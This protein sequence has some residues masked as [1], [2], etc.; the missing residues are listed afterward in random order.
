MLAGSQFLLGMLISGLIIA[1]VSGSYPALVLSSCNLVAILKGAKTSGSKKSMLLR[2]ILV[3]FQFGVSVGLIFCTIVTSDQLGFIKNRDLGFNKD[4]VIN[5]SGQNL[6]QRF[7][8][9]KNEVQQNS[10]ILD[11]TV[12]QRLP[13]D[14]GMAHFG[15]WEG[16]NEGEKPVFYKNQVGYDFIDFYE[17]EIVEGRNFS[18]EYPSDLD[19]AYILNETAVKNIG[20]GDPIGKKF[21]LGKIDGVIVGVLKDFHFA[22]LK[23]KIEPLA[24]RLTNEGGDWISIKIR[25]ENIKSSISFLEK[26][27]QTY[28]PGYPFSFSFLDDGF[29]RMYKKEK[30]LNDS[31]GYFAIIAIFIAYLGLFGLVSFSAERKTKE[32]GIRKVVGAS[33]FGIMVLHSKEFMKWVILANVIA[34]PAAYFVMNKWLQT[35]AYRINIGVGTFILSGAVAFV[36]AVATISFQLFR[37]ATANPVKSLKFE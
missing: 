18:K 3:M 34:W 14:I 28:S 16:Q 20:W 31:F 12:S 27:W 11:V 22:P 26:K 8:T 24:F 19:S 15:R 6:V 21:G 36:F 32:V 4:F 37:A 10:N 1:L 13:I 25:P 35:F 30:K 23:L 9:I 29:D 2:N 7:E 33:V 17:M 5:V